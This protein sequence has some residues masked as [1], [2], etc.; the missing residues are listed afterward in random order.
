MIGSMPKKINYTLSSDELLTIEQAIKHEPDLRVR[1][2]A[3]I[4]RLLHKGHKPEAVADLLSI[5][6][7]QVYWWSNRWRDEG[8][9][10]LADKARSGRPPVGDEA[11]RAKLV[12]VLVTNPQELGYAFTVWNTPRLINYMEEVTG[13][14]VHP[15]TLRNMLDE[16]DYVYRR[17]K[18][19]L[20]NLQDATAKAHAEAILEELKKKPAPAKSNF[21]LWT[22]RP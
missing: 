13:V 22:K 20:G 2:R 21:S 6:R 18:H 4:I 7:G 9:E 19:D 3:H 8:L 11:Y 16:L 14:R 5:S 1:Q 10:G 12:E 15:N 17:P